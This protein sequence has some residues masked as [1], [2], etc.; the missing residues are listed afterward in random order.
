MQSMPTVSLCLITKNEEDC[1]AAC[2]RSVAGLVEEIVLVD[3]GSKDGTVELASRFGAR[4]FFFM[5]QEDFAAARNFGLAQAKGDWILILDADERLAPID[6]QSLVRLLTAPGVEGYFVTIRSLLGSGEEEMRDYVV[7][8]FKNKPLYRFEGTIHEQVAG[9]IKRHSGEGSLA[10]SQITIC[11][12]GYLPERLIAKAKRQRNI[13]IIRQA[14]AI[15]PKD[16]FLLYSLGLEYTQDG[17]LGQGN[18]FLTAALVRLKGDE[19]YF[20]QVIVTLGIGL[21]QTG[22]RERLTWL[23]DK[24]LI[25]FPSDPELCLLQGMSALQAGQWPAAVEG[26]RQAAAAQSDTFVPMYYIQAILGDALFMT[27]CYDQAKTA[28]ATACRLAPQ[29]PYPQERLLRL[30][31]QQS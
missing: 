24:A 19:G 22:Q 2:L 1:I 26:L 5:W 10:T 25:M 20:R 6:R 8:L 15:K 14:L 31:Q 21:L 13:A 3:T 29:W 4:T 30:K 27:G 11:H 16:P 12:N 23:L 18:E 28:F 7:R 9:S 17:N